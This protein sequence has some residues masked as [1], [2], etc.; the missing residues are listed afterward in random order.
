MFWSSAAG[1]W[2]RPSPGIWRA[3]PA[4]PAAS[5]SSSAIRPTRAPR[6]RCRP[7]RSAS[8]SPRRSTSTCRA[9]ASASCA[10]RPE[11]L[12]VDLGLKEPGYLFL[13]SAAGEAVLRANHADPERR[14]LCGRAARSGGSARAAFPGCRRRVSA[15]A[16]HGIANEGW[17][18]GPALM[19]A[20][21]RKARELG[22]AVRRRRGRGAGAATRST[23]A[24][25]QHDRSPDDRAGRRPVVG[26]GRRHG[27][28]RA[29]GRAA[30]TLGVRVRL[31]AKPP[32]CCR[33][34]S[35]RRASWFR[36][37]GRF[38][39]G[40]TTPAPG[41]DPPG[42]PLEVQHQEW[43][44]MV[45]PALADRVPA[46][47]A[48]KVV[49]SLGGLLRVQHLRPERHRRPPSGDRQLCLRHRLLAATASSS[50]RPSAAPSPS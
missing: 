33:S 42:A 6:R 17:F 27:R 44:D 35:I 29:A 7:A 8:S 4:S 47:E 37:E 25:G 32:A 20:F 15:L 9:T 13:A 31:S 39:I 38:Y 10:R 22:V 45:W 28:H 24:L 40:G 2:A 5:S 18:D 21:R 1:R 12:D 49:N 14:G 34:P 26:R 3:I 43:D 41:N 23:L 11:L 48:A 36:P 19:Q 16:S 46:F 30:P 50:R